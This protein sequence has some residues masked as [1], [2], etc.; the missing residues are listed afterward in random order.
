MTRATAKQPVEHQREA[1]QAPAHAPN[2][3]DVE[4]P[5][6]SQE[7]FGRGQHEQVEEKPPFYK[8]SG[9]WALLALIVAGGAI[10]GYLWWQ[11]SRDFISTDDAFVEAHVTNISPRVGG[12]VIKVYVN[13]N[14]DVISGQILLELDPL[15][16]QQA[17]ES[18]L[19]QQ[20]IAEGQIVQAKA[21]VSA[22]E[23][24][25]G[26]AKADVAAAEAN[27]TQ[28][29]EDLKRYQGADRRAVS[30]QQV[31]A[32]VAAARSTHAALESARQKQ[33]AAEAQVAVANAT[34][35]TAQSQ[36]AKAR[37]AVE[38]ARTQLTYTKIHASQDGR[39]T[40]RS[41]SIGDYVQ[42]GQALMGLVPT[43]K[44]V[45]AN[46]KET[47]IRDMRP[48]Q[49]VTISVDAFGMKLDGRVDSIQAGSGAAFS[50]LPP[51]NATG[52]YVKV[53]QR[54]PVKIAFTQPAP[55]NL[56]PGMSVVPTIDIR[57]H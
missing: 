40:G 37:T 42:V 15:D 39:I 38:Q 9:F 34:V 55:A 19:S 6:R 13:D 47:Q 52:N 26:Q 36:L 23:A 27:A 16:F 1:N 49:P 4:A 11:H 17:L 41:V 43:D 46:F 30:Q 20:Q 54:V 50:L 48:G 12:H 10:A 24:S 45:I 28:A 25:I 3:E 14:Q 33:V 35:A 7:S 21:Q 51:E 44:Y 29:E 57:K 22:A 32:A 53:V 31:D 18:A 8:R 56:G 5:D 2:G